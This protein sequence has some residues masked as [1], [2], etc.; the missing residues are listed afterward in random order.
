MWGW[1][2]AV[3]K[4]YMNWRKIPG[5]AWLLLLNWIAVVRNLTAERSL[6]WRT[7]LQVLTGKTSDISSI[8]TF[9]FW[10]LVEFPAK[11][12]STYNGQMGH[13]KGPWTRG[14]FVGIADGIGHAMTYLALTEDTKQII[15]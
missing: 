3:H 14:R 12:D 9:L 5:E 7:P 4:Y 1:T 2:I 13:Y 10:D 11:K 6:G 15:P 8:L